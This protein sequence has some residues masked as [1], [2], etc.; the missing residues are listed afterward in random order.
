MMNEKNNRIPYFDNIKGLLITLVVFG[1]IIEPFVYIHSLD[2]MY[3]LIYTFHM[4][5]FIFCS[6]YFCVKS[7]KKILHNL[8]IPY[9]LFQ[10][11][12]LLFEKYIL[13]VQNDFTYTTPYWILWYL[14]ACAVWN[15]V[16]NFFDD[17]NI[18]VILVSILIGLI[19]GNDGTV[20]HYL[21][22]SRIISLFPFFLCGYY[23]R[24]TKFDFSQLKNNKIF[25]HVVF[26]LFFIIT[27][28][29]CIFHKYINTDWLLGS[30]PYAAFGYN[31]LVRLCTY[32]VAVINSLLVLVIIPNKEKVFITKAGVDSMSVFLLHGFV[33]KFLRA[34]FNWSIF[35]SNFNIIIMM[36]FTTMLVVIVFSSKTIYNALCRIMTK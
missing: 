31:A 7:Y 35:H 20:A 16:I 28:L 4:P 19:V 34:N 2:I 24:A 18:K 22:L 12:Y 32:I 26:A 36:M 5:L 9:F 14:L 27:L 29:L 8:L 30:N 21:C 6:G 23:C 1:H 17:V 11:L 13:G 33:I 3:K 10:T 15:I 25:K